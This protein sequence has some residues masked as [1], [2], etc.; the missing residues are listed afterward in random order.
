MTE[1]IKCLSKHNGCQIKKYIF[2]ILAFVLFLPNCYAAESEEHVSRASARPQP[3]LQQ[4]KGYWDKAC[5]AERKLKNRERNTAKGKGVEASF[6]SLAKQGFIPA[7]LRRAQST[8][9]TLE[10]ELTNL[11]LEI[12]R[13]Q[14]L[15]GTLLRDIRN[16]EGRRTSLCEWFDDVQQEIE[17]LDEALQGGNLMIHDM[18]YC[19][20]NNI[21]FIEFGSPPDPVTPPPLTSEIR[22]R[23][24]A[25]VRSSLDALC[26]TDDELEQLS[27]QVEG[28]ARKFLLSARSYIMTS[29][30]LR[31]LKTHNEVFQFGGRVP[32]DLLYTPDSYL[33][34]LERRFN[35]D[36]FILRAL[37]DR[38]QLKTVVAST[39]PQIVKMLN[40][41]LPILCRYSDE[42]HHTL[43][44]YINLFVKAHDE[45]ALV[46]TEILHARMIALYQAMTYLEALES[47]EIYTKLLYPKL[48]ARTLT[49]PKEKREKTFKKC[50]NFIDEDN[51]LALYRDR[52]HFEKRRLLYATHFLNVGYRF[53]KDFILDREEAPHPLHFISCAEHVREALQE[54]HGKIASVLS[55]GSFYQENQG[56][57][58]IFVHKQWPYNIRVDKPKRY[59][60]IGYL[61]QH[62][63]IA[64]VLQQESDGSYTLNKH[65]NEIGK[66]TSIKK[67]SGRWASFLIPHGYELHT[68]GWWCAK[69]TGKIASDADSQ[70]KIASLLDA[71]HFP[72]G[73]GIS[74]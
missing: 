28:E 42:P 65:E 2:S 30:Y 19:N 40:G 69:G 44:V 11:K 56:T 16:L 3:T 4:L 67:A 55:F 59:F 22:Q 37:T 9:D 8:L 46:G 58:I 15:F 13:Q 14:N 68:G 1:E 35:L 47:P 73:A 21:C 34:D 6:Q 38:I 17:T 26:Q 23:A 51:A 53:Y 45:H 7:R 41:L 32:Q 71:A 52:H 72:L 64:G 20:E 61:E 57:Q 66:F 29:D 5:E 18:T 24:H 63:Y 62:P 12:L 48:Y 39:F 25:R 36:G 31:T 43:W 33:W 60:R 27:Q 10:Q 70:E 54:G 49:K 74:F 50:H